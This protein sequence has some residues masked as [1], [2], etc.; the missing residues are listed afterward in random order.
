M[1]LYPL[2]IGGGLSYGAGGVIQVPICGTFSDSIEDVT[3]A[4]LI[5]DYVN[6][7]EI[8]E[9]GPIGIGIT[10]DEPLSASITSDSFN[11]VISDDSGASVQIE[12]DSISKTII[13]D[14]INS[15]IKC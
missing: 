7:V 8:V 4:M 14:N 15:S 9:Q 1:N 10:D 11:I 13:E 3:I 6:G 12:D 5:E 2:G